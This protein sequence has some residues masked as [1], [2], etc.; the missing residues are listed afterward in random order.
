MATVD[1]LGCVENLDSW[2]CSL[3]EAKPP[4]DQPPVLVVAAGA[5]GGALGGGGGANEAALVSREDQPAFRK[6]G[7]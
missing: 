2:F 6:F 7:V 3:I 4:F 1:A 5:G